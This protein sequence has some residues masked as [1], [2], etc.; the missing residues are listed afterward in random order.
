MRLSV[1]I[2]AFNEQ[3]TIAEIIKKVQAIPIDKEI[4]AVD[5]GSTDKTAEILR[6]LEYD[7]LRVLSHGSNRGKGGALKTA[8]SHVNGDVIIIQD[9]D[10][11]YDP[12]EYPRLIEPIAEGHAEVVYGSRV[13]SGRP[14]RMYMFWHRVGNN[15]LALLTN[16]LYNTTLTDM[17][18]GYKVF[19]KKVIDNMNIRSRDFTVEP[20]ITA[21][22][23][24]RQY[25]IYEIPISYYGRN[26]SEG[27]KIRWWHGLSAVWALLRYRFAD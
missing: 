24:K 27:K 10:L 21:K 5:D 19:V 26:Y 11:E 13:S 9:A 20:E 15:F 7:N 23:L 16:L 2:P 14:Q 22:I 3:D 8:F 1:V 6:G 12:R 18:T 4:I 17:E 25:R